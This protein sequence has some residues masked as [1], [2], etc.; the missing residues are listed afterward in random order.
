MFFCPFS[1]SKDFK[2]FKNLC[3]KIL[4]N[5]LAIELDFCS[6]FNIESKDNSVDYSTYFTYS[7]YV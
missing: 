2:I 3:Y 6:S 4:A 7:F 1:V 5:E